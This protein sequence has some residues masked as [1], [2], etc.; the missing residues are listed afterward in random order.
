MYLNNPSSLENA[1]QDNKIQFTQIT[2]HEIFLNKNVTAFDLF[3]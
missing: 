1:A 2:V 3:L